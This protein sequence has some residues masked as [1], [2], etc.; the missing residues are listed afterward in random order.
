MNILFAES[1]KVTQKFNYK[2]HSCPHFL[3]FFPQ[4]PQV[5]LLTIDTFLAPK[6]RPRLDWLDGL[7]HEQADTAPAARYF[8]A[9]DSA[10]DFIVARPWSNWLPRNLSQFNTKSK[11][12][13]TK[14]RPPDMV[15][16]TTV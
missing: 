4:E 11:A 5:S 3:H 6:Q 15:Q 2:R 10:S 16:L 9:T 12:L 1:I 13:Q 7:G 14:L 8:L